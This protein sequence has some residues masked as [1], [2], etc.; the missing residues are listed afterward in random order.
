MVCGATD[1]AKGPSRVRGLDVTAL[2]YARELLR[3]DVL[4]GEAI[5]VLDVETNRGSGVNVGRSRLETIQAPGPRNGIVVVSKSSS[6]GH[7]AEFWSEL[8][9]RPRSLNRSKMRSHPSPERLNAACQP[10]DCIDLPL[11]LEV[12]MSETLG[13]LWN[14]FGSDH[15][16]KNGSEGNHI[17]AGI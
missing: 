16:K 13:V 6:W 3:G 17:A 5:N 8:E 9:R 14:D 4:R 7:T 10:R 11:E 2:A 1:P 12:S 15:T